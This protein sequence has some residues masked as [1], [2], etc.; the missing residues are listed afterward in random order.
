M[1]LPVDVLNQILVDLPDKDLM[2]LCE[3]NSK[4]SYLCQNER[5][6]QQKVKNVHKHVHRI[7]KNKK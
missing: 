7:I 4:L 6:W 2:K 3:S 1:D 5:L